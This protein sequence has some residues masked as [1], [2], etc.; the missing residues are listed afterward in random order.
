MTAESFMPYMSLQSTCDVSELP[1]APWG[2]A[3]LDMQSSQLTIGVM[4]CSCVVLAKGKVNIWTIYQHHKVVTLNIVQ[5]GHLCDCMEVSVMHSHGNAIFWKNCQFSV[6]LD[7]SAC[8]YMDTQHATTW[9][10]SCNGVTHGVMQ[11]NRC[12][13]CS[14]VKFPKP[15][16]FLQDIRVHK[17]VKM[18]MKDNS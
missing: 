3:K 17:T 10:N 1:T 9:T 15:D 16:Q 7:Y 11:V 18:D 8:K 14:R 6:F 13:D 4:C 12:P 5:S 2:A